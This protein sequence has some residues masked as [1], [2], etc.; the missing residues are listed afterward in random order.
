MLRKLFKKEYRI[1]GLIDAYLERLK[2]AMDH[3]RR[4]LTVY[5]EKG[6]S[7]EF[8]ALLDQT[9]EAESQ[10][11]DIRYEIETLMYSKALLPES[12]GDILGLLEALDQIPGLFEL[13][14]HMM[15]TQKLCIPSFLIVDI[16][17]LVEETLECCSLLLAQVESLFKK[18]DDIK[19][20]VQEIDV[21]ESRCDDIERR[22]ITT[23]F[24]GDVDPFDK[25]QLKEVVIAM[26]DISDQADRVSRRIYIISIKRRV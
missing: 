5:F 10:A 26:G 9:H 19:S 15:H 1:E 13:V 6:F 22:L 23:I 8:D 17:E 24:E 18:T 4:A 16:N 21:R 11:D 25:L 20:L 2:V 12:R 7:Q 14:L 3:F